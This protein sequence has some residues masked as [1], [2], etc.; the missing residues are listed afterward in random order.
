V[1]HFVWCYYCDIASNVTEAGDVETGDSQHGPASR[2]M[3]TSCDRCGQALVFVQDRDGWHNSWDEPVRAWPGAVRPLSAEVPPALREEHVE[4]RKCLDAKAYTAAV[5][6]VRR[7]VEGVCAHHNVSE[8]TL[9][10]SLIKMRDEGL[11]DQRLLDWANALRG[12]GNEGAHYTGKHVSREDALDALSFSEAMLDYLFVLTAKFQE[13]TAR[14]AAQA[15]DAP[16]LVE[17]NG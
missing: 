9:Q 5:V 6:M 17:G 1:K 13:F 12:L 10:K 11:L 7:T 3:L 15:E 4:A 16:E 8:R 2:V 14:R